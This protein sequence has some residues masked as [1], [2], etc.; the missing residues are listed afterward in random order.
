MLNKLI[1]ASVKNR[2]LVL[3]FTAFVTL[4]GMYALYQTPVDAIPDLSDVQVIIFTE[5]PGQAPQVVEDQ[6]TYPLTSAMLAV[7]FA[8]VVR[9]YSFFG[10]SF[11]YI[12]FEDGTDMYWARS[13]VLEYLNYV[14]SRLPQGVTPTL[15]PDAT[16]VGWVYEYVLDGGDQYDL[17]QLR[18]IQDWYLRY[19]LTS[20]PGVSEVASIGGY[21]K[22]YQVE[23]DPNKLLAY[24]IPIQKVR[25]AIQ[26]SNNDVG[27]KLVELGETEFMVRGLGYIK[28]IQDIENIPI[29]VDKSGTP[30]TIRQVADVH[31][32]PELRR[33]IAE[34]NGEGEAVGGVVIMR[35]GENAL[36][37]I[38]RVKEKLKELEKGLPEGVT[39]HTAYDRSSLIER[40]IDNLKEKLLEESIVVALVTILFLMHFRSAFVAILTLPLGILMAFLIMKAQGLSANIM[41]LSGIAIA[42]GAMVDAAIVMIENA[43]KH[44]EHDGGKKDHW[45]IILDASRE[46]GPALFYSLLIITL[47]FLPVFTLQAQ[48]GRL[49]KPLAFTK[50]YAMAAAALLA[51]TV[52]PVFMGYFIRGKIMPEAKNPINR[53]LIKIYRP[54][55]NGALRFKW[56]T[57]IGAL[58][59]LAV[60]IYP[61]EHIGSEFMPPL[62]EGDL[63]YMPITDPGLSITKAKEI[64]QQTDKIIKSFPEVHHV[65]GKIGRAE[66]ATDPAPLS[67]IETTIMLKPRDEWRPGMTLDK[68]VK[69][70]DA[71]IRFPGLTNAWTMPIKT[72][73]DML[74]TGIKTPIGI[75]IMGP[76]LETLSRLG[77]E[78]TSVLKGVKGT[79]SVFADKAVG[80]NYFDLNIKREEA[81]RYGLTVGGV[82]EVIMSAIG[83][84]NVTHTVEGLERYPVNVRYKRELRDNI[85]ALK[86]V[87]IPTPTGAQIPLS[88]VADIE[89]KKGP[90]VIKSENART[91]AWLYVDIRDMDVGTYVQNARKVVDENVPFPEGYSIVW[92]GQYEY[93]ERAQKRLQLVV[94]ITLVIIFLLLYFNFKNIG[95]SLIVMLS[96]P[97]SLV[98]GIWY[99]YILG[100]NFSVAVGVGFIALAGVA[101]ETG[102][103]ML[104]Y[105]DQA[106][107]TM[108]KSGRMRNMKDLYH[109]I[110]EGAV[111]RVRPKMMTVMAIMAGLIPI[112]WGSGTGSQV[113]KRIAAPMIGGMV[114]STLLTL[115]VIPVIYE[116]YKGREVRKLAADM[117]ADNEEGTSENA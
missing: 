35:Y 13:R 114:T 67:M 76:D 69:E 33:G 58:L 70:M 42:I 46:V 24:N 112:M 102:V 19:E 65:F 84:M 108:K 96:L 106:Y 103:I 10:L 109:A 116:L 60:S 91:T 71:A 8:K 43:H 32:G 74:S 95:E 7:P 3:I 21:V 30:I 5:Y 101:A 93:M 36:K 72:R 104:I 50:T 99:L 6:V 39:I 51:L 28:S 79:L 34:W 73:I 23:V 15:G 53:F 44:M 59:V 82:Q 20:V 16:G 57:L 22:Q 87:L 107:N 9:G 97:F 4:V 40:G 86:R 113:M 63:L 55:I 14:S 85:E 27:G 48:E 26:K 92:S 1:E 80:G 89:I 75:K 111:N 38:E 17:Q 68:L 11:V 41:S 18:S 54:V 83:G 81:A 115:I 77:E 12:I 25:M 66:S 105:L 110:I 117:D 64:L 29:G 90:P 94:P 61:L 62:N 31:I 98:G 56:S 37:T 100:Y 2:F 78:I 45:Q 88:Y 49:F 52:V 47:S